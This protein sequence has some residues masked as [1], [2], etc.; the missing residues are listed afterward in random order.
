MTNLQPI[1]PMVLPI[2]SKPRKIKNAPR[3]PTYEMV[4]MLGL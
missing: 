4:E 1:Q 3:K 2:P